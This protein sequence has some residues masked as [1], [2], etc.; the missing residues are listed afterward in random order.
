MQG[1]ASQGLEPS[2][3]VTHSSSFSTSCVR[4]RSPRSQ[5]QSSSFAT[6]AP[7]MCRQWPR[8]HTSRASLHG[9]ERWRRPR[10][11][12]I[13]SP[14]ASATSAA[15]SASDSSTGTIVTR[16]NAETASNARSSETSRRTTSYTSHLAA[17][18]WL[19]PWPRFDTHGA[20]ARG[21]STRLRPCRGPRSAFR[22]VGGAMDQCQACPPIQDCTSAV[23]CTS[24]ST[25]QCT[26]CASGTYL[27][28]GIRICACHV[29]T[30]W[31]AAGRRTRL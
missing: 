11:P 3:C 24:A 17:R 19:R 7:C 5:R 8:G 15:S 9:V 2:P 22:G 1:L 28:R 30:S 18:V 4:R 31:S 13:A 14:G 26:S 23:T 29:P 6:S 27:Q 21:S 20:S 12:V 16:R 10:P 25:S